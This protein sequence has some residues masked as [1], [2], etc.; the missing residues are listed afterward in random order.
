V[1][2]SAQSAKIGLKIRRPQGRG[3]SSPPPGTSV[4]N[5]LVVPVPVPQTGLTHPCSTNLSSSFI[6]Y[7]SGMIVS[8]HGTMG[9]RLTAVRWTSVRS[10]T[11][12]SRNC[13]KAIP[14]WPCIAGKF[15]A[16]LKPCPRT[17][18][19]PC[20]GGRTEVSPLSGRE[21]FLEQ[22]PRIT[23]RRQDSRGD[24]LPNPPK[25]AQKAQKAPLL[26][27]RIVDIPAGVKSFVRWS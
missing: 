3:G 7:L 2:G 20:N 27:R 23:F 22:I 14:Q 13:S 1:Q 9:G 17:K 25:S 26:M 24:G 10:R 18:F 21:G 19:F 12:S 11:R 4:V 15:A 16:R 6:T 5:Q 8:N